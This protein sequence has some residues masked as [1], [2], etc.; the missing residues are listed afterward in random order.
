VS[1]A[2][3]DL[4][5]DEVAPSGDGAQETRAARGLAERAAR[6]HHA[7]DD[8]VLV[9]LPLRPER[10]QQLP[11]RDDAPG[12]EHEVQQQL[13]GL[14]V[15]RYRLT[16]LAQDAGGRFQLEGSESQPG[17]GLSAQAGP[18]YGPGGG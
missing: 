3:G 9:G 15:E 8:R 1:L 18:R 4:G 14:G 17:R 7:V 10:V 16:A 13:E 11:A 5:R 12:T 6:L 2:C